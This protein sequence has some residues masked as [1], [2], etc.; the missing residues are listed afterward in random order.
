MNDPHDTEATVRDILTNT[1]TVALVG[2]SPKP[3]RPSHGVMDFLMRKGYTV[4]PVNPTVDGPILGQPVFASL[5]DL[6]GTP[7]MVDVFRN[8]D[9]A[10]PVVDEAAEIGA[11]FVWLQLGV[12]NDAAA[13]RARAKGLK[14]VQNRCP[15]IE[16]PRLG[17]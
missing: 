2:A 8:S 16:M 6:P 7:D 17:L 15:A 3:N 13:E 11:R 1:K 5:K 14:V 12:I 10:G 9:D 4:W